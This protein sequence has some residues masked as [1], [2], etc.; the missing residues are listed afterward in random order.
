MSLIGYILYWRYYSVEIIPGYAAL[1]VTISFFSGIIIMMLGIT[2]AYVE[3]IFLEVKR[4][5]NYI[6]KETLGVDT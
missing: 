6:V 4:R 2:G 3:R 5:P 1:M